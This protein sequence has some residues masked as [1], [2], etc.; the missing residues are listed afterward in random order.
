MADLL[1]A[2]GPPPRLIRVCDLDAVV[3][4]F[5]DGACEP[6]M[7]TVGG[8]LFEVG[9]RPEAFGSQVPYSVVRRW[10]AGDKRQVIGQAEIAPVA[11]ASRIWAERLRG[12]FCICWIDQDAARQAIIKGYSPVKESVG[13]VEEIS[14]KL[15]TLGALVWYA[16]VPSSCNPADYPSRLQWDIFFTF[17]PDARRV[18][19]PSAAWD[20]C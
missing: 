11:L 8:C 18:Q 5:C 15:T 17:F 13:M 9:R 6:E 16:R 14:L 1:L 10:R 2:G 20:A 19:V 7:V 4:L 3:H 12:R